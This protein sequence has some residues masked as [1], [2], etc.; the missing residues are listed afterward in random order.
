MRLLLGKVLIESNPNEF[1]LRIGR[2]AKPEFKTRVSQ[3]K[4][5]PDYS[6][7]GEPHFYRTFEEV[8][9]NIKTKMLYASDA[10]T[11]QELKKDLAEIDAIIK[12]IGKAF[13]VK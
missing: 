2:V 7:F 13:N 4:K 12:K 10:T 5:L 9:A 3:G 8:M 1:I 11:L 6:D